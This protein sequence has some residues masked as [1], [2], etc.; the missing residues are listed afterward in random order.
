M[1]LL[2]SSRPLPLGSELIWHG[3]DLSLYFPGE[4]EAPI[5]SLMDSLS[6][7][8]RFMPKVSYAPL[9]IKDLITAAEGKEWLA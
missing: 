9:T 4:F 1:M 8:V 6:K 3:S 2:S 7:L 5:A